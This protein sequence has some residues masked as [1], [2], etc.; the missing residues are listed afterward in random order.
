MKNAL[1]NFRK[2][3]VSLGFAEAD[4]SCCLANPRWETQ[5]GRLFLVG[6]IPRGG[7]DRN[8]CEGLIAAVAWDLVSD[9]RVFDSEEDYLSRRSIFERK[10][11][12]GK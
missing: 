1:P 11:R 2:K 7:S 4:N 5:G 12:K 10:K 6:T 9:Y 3:L 8:W